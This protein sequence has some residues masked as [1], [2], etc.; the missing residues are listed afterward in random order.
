M[1]KDFIDYGKLVDD[2][3][4]IIVF[5]VL[6]LVGE[7][8]LPGEHHFFI[9]FLTRH[10][11][12]V[13][14]EMLRNKYP[15]EMTVVMQYQYQDLKVDSRGFG[16]TLSFS[17]RKESIYI[18]YSAITTFADPSVQFGLQF[19]EMDHDEDT[20]EIFD[21]EI[22]ST[23]A[24]TINP[25]QKES[26]ATKSATQKKNKDDNNVVVLDQFRSKKNIK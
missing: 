22:I 6:K 8:G 10:P 19:R 13:L 4:H 12:V 23:V 14:S 1:K 3:M 18:P 7:R 11:G 25:D 21:D 20:M 2:A 26:G 15:R 17:G 24:S 9:S 16:V 5:K